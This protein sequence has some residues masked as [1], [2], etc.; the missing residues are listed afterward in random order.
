MQGEVMITLEALSVSRAY[1]CDYSE[2]HVRAERRLS[3][4]LIGLQ[5]R[6]ALEHLLRCM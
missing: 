6:L 3:C 5:Q 1:L 2:A 4:R